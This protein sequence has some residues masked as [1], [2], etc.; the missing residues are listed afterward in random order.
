MQRGRPGIFL[1]PVLVVTQ[2]ILKAEIYEL[3]EML[4]IRHQSPADRRA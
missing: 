1:W 3:V 4:Y 2:T